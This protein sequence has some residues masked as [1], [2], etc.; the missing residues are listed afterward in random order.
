[1]Y[2]L[3]NITDVIMYTNIAM[4]YVIARVEN[5]ELHWSLSIGPISAKVRRLER[6]FCHGP[7]HNL[8]LGK[9]QSS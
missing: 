6:C 9:A 2:T 4:P 8:N 3:N 1:M 7:S 5:L